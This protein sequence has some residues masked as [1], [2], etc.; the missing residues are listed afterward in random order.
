MMKFEK[1]GDMMEMKQVSEK[2]HKKTEKKTNPFFL[3]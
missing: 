3:C 2:R 1:E